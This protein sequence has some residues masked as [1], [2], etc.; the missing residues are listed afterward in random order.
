M[1]EIVSIFEMWTPPDLEEYARGYES[2][3]HFDGRGADEFDWRLV[4]EFPVGEFLKPSQAYGTQTAEEWAAWFAS[5]NEFSAADYGHP[6]WEHLADEEITDPII[7]SYNEEGKWHIWDGWH[8]TGAA[9]ATDRPT[10]P[11]VVGTPKQGMAQ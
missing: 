7:M 10:V 8:R 5:E 3:N 11:A 9:I 2:E 6:Y 4:P 1:E